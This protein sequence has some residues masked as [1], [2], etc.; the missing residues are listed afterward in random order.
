[1]KY[2]IEKNV[3]LPSRKFISEFPFDQMGI[4]DSFIAIVTDNVNEVKIMH[5][6]LYYAAKIM[7]KPITITTRTIVHDD[8]LKTLR[9]WRKS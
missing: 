6:K 1:M 8:G 9:V 3:P 7:K 5:N 2:K 4:G